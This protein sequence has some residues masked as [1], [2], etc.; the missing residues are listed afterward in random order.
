MR[1]ILVFVV[2]GLLFLLVRNS[3]AVNAG[4]QGLNPVL[5]GYGALFASGIV[6]AELLRPI[7][8]RMGAV[9]RFTVVAMIAGL[10]WFGF[11]QARMAGI[12]P[13]ALSDPSA[14]SETSE[15][16]Q[17]TSLP[18]AWDGVYRAVAQINNMSIGVLIETGTPLVILQYEEAERLG[19]NPSALPFDQ[20]L[21]L[22]DRKIEAALFKL[23]SVRIDDVEQLN[24]K[25]A[26]A[27]KGAVETSVIGLSFLNGLSAAAI[28]NEQFY[29]RQ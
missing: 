9:T 24:V 17:Q 1:A 13:L 26:I 28:I 5:L 3:T 21:P 16:I 4:E 29:L 2:L 12:L 7:L 18:L 8:A 27:A 14:V 6:T 15:P 25:G 10:V 23:F 22:G 11:E 20:R 19:F